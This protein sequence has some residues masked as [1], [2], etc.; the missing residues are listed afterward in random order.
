MKTRPGAIKKNMK[1]QPG[2]MK[3]NLGPWKTIKTDLKP[4]KANL[5]P[6][7]TIK[8]DLKPWKTNLETHRRKWWFFV[9]HIH[10]III[11]I[12]SIIIASNMIFSHNKRWSPQGTSTAPPH[13]LPPARIFWQGRTPSLMRSTHPHRCL[14]TCGGVQANNIV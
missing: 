3:T 5:R 13:T 1:N 8:T 14:S 10:F 11:Y 4:W 6:W 9:T 12:S 7:K 2:T